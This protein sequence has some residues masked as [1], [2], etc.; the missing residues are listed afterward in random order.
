[1]K[2]ATRTKLGAATDEGT[3]AEVTVAANEEIGSDGEGGKAH[4]G[5]RGWFASAA[6]EDGGEEI[7][8]VIWGGKNAR[9][10]VE[11]D[12]WVVSVRGP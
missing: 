5:P 11:G 10:E 12:G 7:G 1:M 8:T 9:G 6:L 2:D 3:W 4:P